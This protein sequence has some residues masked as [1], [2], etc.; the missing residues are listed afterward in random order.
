[1]I[2]IKA[3]RFVSSGRVLQETDTDYARQTI[4]GAKQKRQE[5]N[6]DLMLTTFYPLITFRLLQWTM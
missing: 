2:E 6:P 5:T 3:D 4:H 1:M